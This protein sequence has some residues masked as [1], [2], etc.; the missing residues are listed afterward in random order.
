MKRL[1]LALELFFQRQVGDDDVD[2]SLAW[3]NMSRDIKGSIYSLLAL[4][5][6]VAL[7]SYVA[8]DTINVVNGRLDHVNNLGGIVGAIFSEW[9]LGAIG[10]MGYAIIFMTVYVAYT[11][12]RGTP[13][14]DNIIKLIGALLTTLLAAI[15]CRLIFR[16]HF[17]QMSLF[18]GGLVGRTTGDWLLHYFNSTGALL[19]VGGA[20]IITGILTTGLSI[21][22]T[23]RSMF[24]DD[25]DDDEQDDEESPPLKVKKTKLVKKPKKP[26]QQAKKKK[27]K[28][29]KKAVDEDDEELDEQ[30]DEKL[31]EEEVD[32]FDE[33]EDDEEQDDEER[34]VGG[35]VELKPMKV[36]YSMPSPR[37]LKSHSGAKKP[38]KGE[39]KRDS[40]MLCEHLLNFNITGKIT[41]VSL[42]PVLTT[43]EYKP[44]AGVKL[45]AIAAVQA[46]L[47]ILLGT[48]QLRIV[49]PIPG[50]TVVGIEVPRK[51]PEVISL[52]EM[53][54]CDSFYEKKL[55]LPVPLGKA[56]DG[57]VVLG[58]LTAMPHLLVAGATGSGKSVFVN[59]LITGLLFRKTP[60]Q[61]RLIL[62]DPKMLELNIFE[63][64]PHLISN[65]ITNNE[66]AF[67]AL[68]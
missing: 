47:G 55:K 62:V 3:E 40:A 35:F 12:F 5:E 4:F 48:P 57:K 42:G 16:D 46:D 9:V 60:Q 22:R 56:T 19:L 52:K 27:P 13:F 21:V 32:E 64:I 6:L 51:V 50:K 49:A 45:K 14:K 24:D 53:V 20:F 68:Q 43:Y 67:N 34:E 23:V 1:R 38:S 37:L 44:S 66:Y 2:L 61:L 36:K 31:D 11:S 65:V 28:K 18:Q 29:K 33:E 39:L 59:S 8:V 63:G 25:D 15:T 58:D 26:Q 17:P 54:A 30:I 10:V 7:T 41:H